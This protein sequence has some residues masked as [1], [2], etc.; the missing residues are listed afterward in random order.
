[1]YSRQI[2]FKLSCHISLRSDEIFVFPNHS[3]LPITCITFAFRAPGAAI[4]WRNALQAGRSRFRFPTVAL[5]FFINVILSAVLWALELTQPLT[6]MSTSA[7]N[8]TTFLFG[9]SWN[10]GASTT[11]NPQGLSRPVMGLLYLYLTFEFTCVNWEFVLIKKKKNA[12]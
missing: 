12:G 6:E 2:K 11:W 4:G 3:H 5:E 8:L 1:M 7:D 9:L 10:L